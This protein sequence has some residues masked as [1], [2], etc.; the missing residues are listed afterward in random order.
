[1]SASGVFITA[2][3]LIFPALPFGF[4]LIITVVHH[5][6][7]PPPGILLCSGIYLCLGVQLRSDVSAFAVSI[8]SFSFLPLAADDLDLSVKERCLKPDS[9]TRT[10]SRKIA[11]QSG[12]IYSPGPL[13]V[14]CRN[15]ERSCL[16][17]Q[18]QEN[19]ALNREKPQDG[20]DSCREGKWLII[21]AITVS[22]H[23][24]KDVN[25]YC[26]LSP[27]NWLLDARVLQEVLGRV[28]RSSLDAVQWM[29]ASSSG[30]T[31]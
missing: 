12:F 9:L 17:Q 28:S 23:C 29:W 7:E 6:S 5:V 15:P 14:L 31:C 21:P 26:D 3:P 27:L 13:W 16:D 19:L 22:L 30:L 25:L 10:H 24:A 8:F 20:P 4:S 18:W 2:A 1:M 11:A